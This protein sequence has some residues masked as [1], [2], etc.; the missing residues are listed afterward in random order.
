MRLKLPDVSGPAS[1]VKWGQYSFY[2][3]LQLKEVTTTW[4]I[5][6]A[7]DVNNVETTIIFILYR[8]KVGI[9]HI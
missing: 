6:N 5:F 7:A 4:S 1:W 9:K 2:H 8:K 3:L